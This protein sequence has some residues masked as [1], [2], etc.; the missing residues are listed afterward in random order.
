MASWAGVRLPTEAELEIALVEQGDLSGQLLSLDGPVHPVLQ[1]NRRGFNSL[2]G[3]VWE[4]TQSNYGAYPGYAPPQGA[5]GEYNGK[6]MCSQLVLKGGSCATPP[7]HVRPTY[8]NF[9]PPKDRCQFSG[10][11]FAR[12][13]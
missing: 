8:R 2:V 4:W 13:A 7:G 1:Q 6:F 12:D 3:G 9:F 10:L 5:V 11:R